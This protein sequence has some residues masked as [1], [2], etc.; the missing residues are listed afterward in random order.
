MLMNANY[1]Y[2]L[3]VQNTGDLHLVASQKTKKEVDID[4]ILNLF[5]DNEKYIYF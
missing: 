2:K 1:M 4:V 5:Y 3:Y